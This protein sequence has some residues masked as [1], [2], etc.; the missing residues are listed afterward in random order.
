MI[1][2]Y[3]NYTET[4]RPTRTSRPI[5]TFSTTRPNSRSPAT[6][7][8]QSAPVREA[9]VEGLLNT[10]RVS[11]AGSSPP[12]C[13]ARSSG[14]GD[15]RQELDRQ[16]AR[17]G[18]RRSSSQH[19]ARIVPDRQRAGRCPRRVPPDPADAWDLGRSGDHLE[20]GRRRCLVQR[21][22]SGLL[23]ARRLRR[24]SPGSG[25]RAGDERVSDR[26]GALPRSGL[27]GC[28]R[29]C[30]SS[31]SPDGSRS[32]TSARSPSST[33]AARPVACGSIPSFF[34]LFFA[35]VIYTAS[36]IAEIVPRVDPGGRRGQGEAADA[37][38]LSGFQRMWY[39]IL[40]QAFRIAHPADRQPVPQP[41]QELV[42]RRGDRLLRPHPRCADDRSATGHPPCLCS[43][44]RW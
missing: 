14:S 1:W 43:P 21:L 28:R 13:S 19:A 5:S 3:G 2:L 29:C 42:A 9:L 31:W 10:L 18:L 44:S 40:P 35:L 20:P 25:G 12:R 39:I 7:C 22:R 23:S 4:T 27:V 15:C 33:D 17:D 24:A 32:A 6:R 37:V 34:A 38:A 36:H 41:D 30:S 26:T 11:M 16:Q 8:R